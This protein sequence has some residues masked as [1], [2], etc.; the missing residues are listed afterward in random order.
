MSEHDVI[1]L[2]ESKCGPLKERCHY[3]NGLR[4]GLSL[5]HFF[6][7][8]LPPEIGELEHLEVLNVYHNRLTYLPPEIGKLEHLKE[9]RLSILQLLLGKDEDILKLIRFELSS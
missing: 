1:A 4:T 9:R 2:L 8:E 5:A 6:L 3:T 7:E